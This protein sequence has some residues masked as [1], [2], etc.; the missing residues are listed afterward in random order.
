[1]ATHSFNSIFFSN[2]RIIAH[3]CGCEIGNLA[4]ALIFYTASKDVFFQHLEQIPQANLICLFW[5][6]EKGNL[7]VSFLNPLL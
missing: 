7:V 1:M 6:P 4:N 5:H 3:L 2:L